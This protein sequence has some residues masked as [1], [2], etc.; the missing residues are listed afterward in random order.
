M[1]IVDR[2]VECGLDDIKLGGSGSSAAAF[3]WTWL[4]SGC[5][6]RSMSRHT[7]L[8]PLF[9]R[10]GGGEHGRGVDDGGGRWGLCV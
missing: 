2:G 7:K 8:I 5:H 3:E 10:T 9:P 6:A 1:V 4:I